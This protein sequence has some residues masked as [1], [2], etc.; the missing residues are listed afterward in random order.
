MEQRFYGVIHCA[1]H[2]LRFGNHN[3][4]V[5][6]KSESNKLLPAKPELSHFVCVHVCVCLCVCTVCVISYHKLQRKAVIKLS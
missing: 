4:I 3:W 2:K 6:V 5:A 1:N